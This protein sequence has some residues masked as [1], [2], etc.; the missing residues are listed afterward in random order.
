MS[1]EGNS[2]NSANGMARAS[3]KPSMPIAGP[4][5]SPLVA[6]STRSVPMIGPVQENDTRVSVNAMK[7][8]PMRP[9]VLSARAS[10][11]LMNFEGSLMSNAPKNDTA[12]TTS[13]RKKMMLQTALV[14]SALSELA[15]N[16]RVTTMP[17]STY[18]TT[19]ESP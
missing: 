11:R 1:H 19:M 14:D 17:R 8:M 15:P 4:N 12:N 5:L 2:A 18:I 6:A 3:E 9:V 10:I 13:S 16:R 7:K